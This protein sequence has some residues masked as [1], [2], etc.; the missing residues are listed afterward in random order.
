MKKIPEMAPLKK[1][2]KTVDTMGWVIINQTRIAMDDV[3]ENSKISQDF[4]SENNVER[5]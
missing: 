1:R 5:I 3:F 4:T 2:K